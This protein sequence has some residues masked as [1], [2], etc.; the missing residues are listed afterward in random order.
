MLKTQSKLE[1]ISVLASYATLRSISES[2]KYQNIYQ[3]LS[4]FIKYVIISEKKHVFTSSDMKKML[5]KSFGFDLPDAVVR[6]AIKGASFT[7]SEPGQFVVT[8]LEYQQDDQFEKSKIDADKEEHYLADCLLEYA[9]KTSPEVLWDSEM[10]MQELMTYLLEPDHEG[11][12]S[13]YREL[14]SKFILSCEDNERIQSNLNSIREGCVLYLGLNS[15]IAEVGSITNRITLYLA[16]EILFSLA[17]Y[18]GVIYKDLS[19]DLI[20]LVKKANSPSKMISLLYFPETKKEIEDFFFKAEK[21]I[22]NKEPYLDRPA[23]KAIINGCSN[24]TDVAVKLAD[25]F[26]KL[27]FEYGITCDEKTRF[28]SEELDAYNLETLEIDPQYEEDLRFV[29]HINKLRRG[30][31]SITELDSEYLYVT[32]TTSTLFIS[33]QETK[34]ANSEERDKNERMFEYA[35]NL[36]HITNV[37]WYKLGSG[38]GNQGYPKNVQAV[39]KAK[40]LLSSKIIQQISKSF[41]KA[42]ADYESG[43]LTKEQVASRMTVLRK[44]PTLPED[45]TSDNIDKSLDFTDDYLD[46]YEADAQK[47]AA[48]MAE[49]ASE[50]EYMRTRDQKHEKEA[51]QNAA[52]MAQMAQ[53][54]EEMRSKG[55]QQEAQN[56]ALEARLAAFEQEKEEQQKAAQ[57]KENIKRFAIRIAEKALVIIVL[58]VVFVWV[59]MQLF[60]TENDKSILAKLSIA[61]LFIGLLVDVAGVF[62]LLY[63]IFKKDYEKIFQNKQESSEHEGE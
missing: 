45:L 19:M 24:S 48:A 3:L 10:M 26:H 39:L 30:K 61:G 15:N 36:D 38:F 23:M 55:Q 17:G 27:K 33:R 44:K 28:Y 18:N 14:I 35:V 31:K 54:L 40:S 9:Q 56:K 53:E 5:K 58:I 43:N 4:E 57:R 29:S 52:T 34:K 11:G 6:T 7:R 37:L 1:A 12:H 41:E 62:G 2:K 16:T 60:K 25:F 50:L 32:N 51:H 22:E 59:V 42:K 13:E 21:I 8:D 47:N 63:S 20:N 49:M 46:Q